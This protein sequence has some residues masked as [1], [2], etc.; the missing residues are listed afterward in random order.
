M[1]ATIKS[2]VEYTYDKVILAAKINSTIEN[3]EKWIAANE[4]RVIGKFPTKELLSDQR[5]GIYA[6]A[7][8]NISKSKMKEIQKRIIWIERKMTLRNVNSFLN[9]LSKIF[10]CDKV[11]VKISY[12]E[13]QIQIARKQWVKAKEEAERLLAVYKFQKGDFYKKTVNNLTK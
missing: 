2:R 8:S 10:G 4:Y 3:I 5:V 6:A 13:E 9:L 7:W 1:E 12:K 11:Q